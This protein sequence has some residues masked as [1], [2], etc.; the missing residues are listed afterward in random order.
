MK[1]SINA[2][3]LG[4]GK[5]LL[6]KVLLVT[7]CLAVGSQAYAVDWL[8][9][10]K[11]VK[12]LFSHD[13][14][15]VV[16]QA[17]G[18]YVKIVDQDWDHD[19]RRAPANDQPASI[20]APHLA[21]V[22]NSLQAWRPEDTPETDNSVPL[23]TNEEISLLAPKLSDAL[24]RAGPKQDVVFAVTGNYENFPQERRRATAAR[25]FVYDGKLNMIF[26]DVLR[27]AADADP[28]D[29]SEYDEPHRA[30]R[31]IDTNGRDIIVKNGI[32]IDHYTYF[33]TPRLDWIQ[34]D[35]P[36]VV[37][38]YGGPGAVNNAAYTAPV[39]SVANA[40]SFPVDNSLSKENRKL[41]EELAHMRKE[42]G[43]NEAGGTAT[44]QP[45]PAPVPAPPPQYRSQPAPA[46][47][48]NT[49]KIARNRNAAPPADKI[50]TPAMLDSIQKRLQL[51]KNL[52]DQGLI[53]DQEYN[54]KRREI[55]EE[56]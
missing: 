11:S 42:A 31:R 29:I 49:T 53:T 3:T 9:P 8:A 47:P 14:S 56:I 1:T 2:S 16:W 44:A 22:L 32:G 7:F 13:D 25:V 6:L 43:E 41:R 30:G 36:Q 50:Q 33:T 48:A 55:V 23:F 4:S 46:A 51:L 45:Q 20:S 18:Q 37:A 52:H 27:P 34:I 39:A 21:V 26:G 5:Q 15:I 40:V 10:V 28:N 38:A 24:N 19:H 17:P 54:A 35:V 12:K